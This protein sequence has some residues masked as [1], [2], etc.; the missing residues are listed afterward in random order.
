MWFFKDQKTKL[1][2]VDLKCFANDVAASAFGYCVV[3]VVVAAEFW[4]QTYSFNKHFLIDTGIMK[5]IVQ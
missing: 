1:G 5:C 4:R 2:L 3:V